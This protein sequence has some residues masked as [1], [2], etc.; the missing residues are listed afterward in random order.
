M[1]L[2]KDG[3]RIIGCIDHEPD[4][5]WSYF[6]GKPSQREVIKFYTTS[7]E[8]ALDMVLGSYRELRNEINRLKKIQS[9]VL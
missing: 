9:A 1:E 6:F 3:R 4:G 8:K 7:R 5:E 2:I